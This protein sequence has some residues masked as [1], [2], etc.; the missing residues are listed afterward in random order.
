MPLAPG[1]NDK[2]TAARRSPKGT[3]FMLRRHDPYRKLTRFLSNAKGALVG[4][5]AAYCADRTTG[6]DTP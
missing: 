1:R 6:Y 5:R 3:A 4:M 2:E